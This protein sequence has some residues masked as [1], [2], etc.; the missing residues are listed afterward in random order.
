M[1]SKNQLHTDTQELISYWADK[2]ES[3]YNQ[4]PYIIWNKSIK[5]VKPIVEQLG[6][7]KCKQLIDNYF[8]IDDEF[9]REAKWSFQVFC[10]S[11]M[12]NKLL[13]I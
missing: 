6:L 1:E 2:W 9:V 10:S 13:T 12:I 5:Q 3:V 4:K 7:E 11:N 8:V